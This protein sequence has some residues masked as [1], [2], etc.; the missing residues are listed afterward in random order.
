VNLQ[1]TGKFR[2][3]SSA[4][5]VCLLL[6]VAVFAVY[7]PVGGYGFVD[8]DD[9]EYFFSNPHVLGGFTGANIKWAFTTADTGNWLPLT[10]LSLMLDVQFFGS[11]A[12]AP[13]IINVLLHAANAMLV[14]ALLRQLTSA[15]WCSAAVAMLFALHPMHVESVAWVAERKDVLSSFFGLL[16]LLFYA[17]YAAVKKAQP[18][19]SSVTS[20]VLALLF[21]VC[22]LMSKSMVVTLPFVM[23][24]LDF[25]P[26]QRFNSS[27]FK[28]LLIEK[29]PF[30][31][32]IVLDSA[33]TFIAQQKGNAVTPLAWFPPGLRIANAFVSY[34]RYLGKIFLP[35]NL[36]TPY[37]PLHYWPAPVVIASFL[38]FVTLCIAAV[39][40]RKKF[41][42]AFTGW[43]WFVGMLVPVIGL[44]QVGAQSMADRYIYLPIV[45]VLVLVVWAVAEVCAISQMPRG[46]MIFCAVFLCLACALRA[47]NQV[48]NWRDD[49]TLFSHALAVTENNNVA[50]HNLGYWY[51]KNGQTNKAM[52]YYFDADQLGSRDPGKLYNAANQFAKLGHWDEAIKIYRRALQLSPNQPDVLNNLGFALAQNKQLPEAAAC[53]EIVLKLQPGSADAHN[54]LA[55]I[56][57]SE[58]NLPDAANQFSNALQL[59]PDNFSICANL[60]GTYDRLGQTNLAVKYYQQAQRLQPENPQVRARLQSL[61]VPPAK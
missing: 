35:V 24:L 59:A 6:A 60:A 48:S 23:L 1:S 13:H 52:D 43:F 2:P 49:G 12:S 5:I 34:A 11:G 10:W 18:P 42:Y 56:L 9:N 33:V 39:A 44:V 22:A 36:A 29:I 61:G 17:R 25:W 54:N 47:R 50:T 15:L 4:G 53:F 16:A 38:L 8:F 40:L 51:Q 55:S 57:F 7:F 20:F 45:G 30:F 28:S 32:A 37:S 19:Q 46:A 27:S 41:P 3:F 26:L 21:F 58:G 31:L 14:F